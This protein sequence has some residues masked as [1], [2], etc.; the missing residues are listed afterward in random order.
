MASLDWNSIDE[1]SANEALIL[2]LIAQDCGINNEQLTGDRDWDADDDEQFAGDR[3]WNENEDSETEPP[4]GDSPSGMFHNVPHSDNSSVQSVDRSEK[5]P[6]NV[7]PSEIT[8][9]H[10]QSTSTSSLHSEQL[11]TIIQTINPERINTNEMQKRSAE[12][13][14][15][16]SLSFDDSPEGNSS[17]SPH[18]GLHSN[19]NNP[20]SS[21]SLKH[22]ESTGGSGNATQAMPDTPNK[23]AKT[24]GSPQSLSKKEQPK[25]SNVAGSSQP[26]SDEVKSSQEHQP[27][28]TSNSY[29]TDMQVDEG[30][31]Q[32]PSGAMASA[33]SETLGDWG[34][35]KAELGEL[36]KVH[37]GQSSGHANPASPHEQSQKTSTIA[38]RTKPGHSE[39]AAQA[40]RP[41]DPFSSNH[42]DHLQPKTAPRAKEVVERLRSNF[43]PTRNSDSVNDEAQRSAKKSISDLISPYDDDWH[44]STGQA[45]VFMNEST[46]QYEGQTLPFIKIPWTGKPGWIESYVDDTALEYLN[47]VVGYVGGRRG[48]PTSAQLRDNQRKRREEE[49]VDI[50]VGDDETCDSII[51]E[52]VK[53]EERK[54]KGK[55]KKKGKAV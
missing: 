27:I 28:N 20:G 15:L 24:A 4:A 41:V 37:G 8:S 12:T 6:D 16:P 39:Q 11:S 54:L 38:H 26:Q 9:V 25:H 10:H 49:P 36:P 13:A 14:G 47:E 51:G 44:T 1:E 42:K 48:G 35:V 43:D 52:M 2:Q 21:Q 33:G 50:L 19:D 31:T 29:A 3:D 23:R 32:S 40:S 18:E 5:L 17:P 45:H 53:R 34:D 22:H 55:G 7:T 30:L 46:I